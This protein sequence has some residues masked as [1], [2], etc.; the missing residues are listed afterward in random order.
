MVLGFVLY[1]TVPHTGSIGSV[2]AF[3]CAFLVII[4]MYGGG[5]STVPAYLKDMFG[6]VRSVPFMVCC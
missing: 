4:S 1:C 5:F 6:T 3:V 2:A